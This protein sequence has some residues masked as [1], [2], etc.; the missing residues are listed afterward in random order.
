MVKKQELIQFRVDSELKEEFFRVAQASGE[1]P[2]SLLRALMQQSVSEKSGKIRA[3]EDWQKTTNTILLE[4]LSI[5]QRSAIS[6]DDDSFWHVY[7]NSVLPEYL[8]DMI[9]TQLQELEIEGEEYLRQY[10][11]EIDKNWTSSYSESPPFISDHL[12]RDR[13]DQMRESILHGRAPD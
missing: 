9:I 13:M 11:R 3:L 1:S 4:I 7:R 10:W 5:F 6:S 8:Q 12:Q 2:S